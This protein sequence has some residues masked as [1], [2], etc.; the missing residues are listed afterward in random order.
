MGC[1]TTSD[2]EHAIVAGSREHRNVGPREA[3]DTWKRRARRAIVGPDDAVASNKSWRPDDADTACESV[4]QGDVR[5]AGGR[6]VPP[7]PGQP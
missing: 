6:R 3:E 7:I 2:I 5:C 1:R 4:E